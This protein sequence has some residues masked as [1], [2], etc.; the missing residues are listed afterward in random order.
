MLK[1]KWLYGIINYYEPLKLFWGLL[2]HTFLQ[3]TTDLLLKT[4]KRELGNLVSVT[5]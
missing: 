5:D 4:I 1:V 2:L 3:Q